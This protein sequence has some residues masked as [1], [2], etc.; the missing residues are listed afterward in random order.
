VLRHGN[1]ALA[2]GIVEN[3]LDETMA[4]EALPAAVLPEGEQRL[5][6][7]ARA[8]APRLPVDVLDVLLI[9]RMGKDVSGVGM[10]TNVIGRLLINGEAEPKRP[11]ISMIACHLLTP[12]SH[13]NACGVG[14]ADIVTAELADSIDHE[15]TRT[16][17]VTSGFLLRGKLPV[18]AAN[19]SEAWAWC[20]RGAGIV[21][22]ATVRAAR[23]VDTLHCN[24]L[25]VTDAVLADL[26]RDDRVEVVEKDLRLHDELG[27]LT[28]F[29]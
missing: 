14:L 8:N 19:A 17:V 28:P 3:A 5:L 16:N 24:E 18:V 20:L 22:A 11:R 4:V 9:D 15:V 25:W 27:D 21:D 13:G 10:D 7:I 2:V 23:I 12:A 26:V 29:G 1:V 6:D